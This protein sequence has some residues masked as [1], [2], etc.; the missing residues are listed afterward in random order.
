MSLDEFLPLDMSERESKLSTSVRTGSTA[1]L[2]FSDTDFM[3][4][5]YRVGT[6]SST[7]NAEPFQ[8]WYSTQ[9]NE[10][11]ERKGGKGGNIDN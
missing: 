2:D 7:T 3:M 1:P 6:K 4:E 8:D 9:E 5:R 10:G 11:E